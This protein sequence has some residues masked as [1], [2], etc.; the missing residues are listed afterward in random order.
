M[1]IN[2]HEPHPLQ[3]TLERLVLL[4]FLLSFFTRL[5]GISP[6][7]VQLGVIQGQTQTLDPDSGL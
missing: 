1:V 4:L 5:P 3:Y 2:E 6:M 7:Y